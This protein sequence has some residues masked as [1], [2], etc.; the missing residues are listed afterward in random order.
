MSSVLGVG[1][2]GASVRSGRRCVRGV[3]AF[4]FGRV[5]ATDAEIVTAANVFVRSRPDGYDTVLGGRG[6]FLSGGQ[7]QRIAIARALVRDTSMLVRDTSMLVRDE[8]TTGLDSE[9]V[10]RLLGPLRRLMA[11]RTTVLITHDLRLATEA[12]H[13]VEFVAG[14][15]CSRPI[16]T[17][18]A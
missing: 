2:F 16:V 9:A 10:R 3:G 13:V 11:G 6:R 17:E 12:D 5:G 14:R 15:I 7:R 1:A 18:S 4:V 8:P